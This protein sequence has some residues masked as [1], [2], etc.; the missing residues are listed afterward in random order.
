MAV[1]GDNNK[2]ENF[3]IIDISMSKKVS[4]HFMPRLNKTNVKNETL[5]EEINNS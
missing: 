5:N 3:K 2:S 4:S 1:G